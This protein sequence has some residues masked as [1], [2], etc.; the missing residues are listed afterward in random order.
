MPRLINGSHPGKWLASFFT[1]GA[2]AEE[3]VLPMPDFTSDISDSGLLKRQF[4]DMHSMI[5]RLDQQSRSSEPARTPNPRELLG[6]LL[7]CHAIS[8]KKNETV[9]R[10]AAEVYG[11]SPMLLQALARPGAVVNKAA[12]APAMTTVSGWAAELAQPA[13]L[14]VGFLQLVAPQSVYSQLSARPGSIRVSLAGRGSVRVPTRALTPTIGGSFVAEGA[15]IPIRQAGLNTVSITPKKCAV[16]SV[17]TEEMFRYSVPNIQDVVT[18]IMSFD[19][20][21]AIDSVLLD[22]NPATAVRPAGL[23][24]GISA[25][26][27]TAGGGL[28]AFAGDI[29]ALTAA[30]EATG[31]LF[32][33]CLIMSASSELMID[34][35]SMSATDNLPIISSPHVPAKQLILV[36]A[37]NFASAEGDE[38]TIRTSK[39]G[40]LHMEDTTPLNIGT[41]GSPATI[42]APA[43]S[44]FQTDCVALRLTQDASW[45]MTRAGRV[46][47]ISS[48]SW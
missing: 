33:P 27:A 20:A 39:E 10:T 47:F 42:A 41:A 26:T 8:Q 1:N 9:A 7:T 43:Q 15:P 28:A 13:V 12:S 3:L 34:T 25:T 31:P 6:R 48:V 30:I 46:A 17:F 22:S 29:R 14:D 21:V 19:T 45:I 44:M 38:P 4:R 36:D 5:S 2:F 11:N 16:C 24:N 32:N 23:L 37:A 40:L 35:L 18:A